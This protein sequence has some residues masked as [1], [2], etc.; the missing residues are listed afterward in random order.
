MTDALEEHEGSVSI[1]GR[2]ITNLRFADDIDGLAGKEEEL[3]SLV[4]RLDTAST[5]YGMQ[6]S[7]EKTKLMTNKTNGI[8][9]D[10]KVNDEKLETVHSFKYLG[11]IVSDQGSKPEVLSR[12]AQT[13]IALNK[14][15]T[16]WN[17]K[18]IALS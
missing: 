5:A 15:N 18:N 12:I 2:T 16:I 4:K 1:G 9:T 14:L 3:A 10:I 11:A 7:A 6:I 8:S 17:D 13:T